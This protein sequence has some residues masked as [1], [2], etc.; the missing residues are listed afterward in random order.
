MTVAAHT[1]TSVPP[2]LT[3][4]L[5][6]SPDIRQRGGHV[7]KVRTSRLGLLNLGCLGTSETKHQRK[8]LDKKNCNHASDIRDGRA[9]QARNSA[10]MSGAAATV[11]LPTPG[12]PV[13][14]AQV[15]IALLV[16]VTLAVRGL[17]TLC[18]CM[19]AIGGG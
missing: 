12:G 16:C 9:P 17:T 10:P 6:T 13:L 15:D 1:R 14:F 7:R 11:M 5:P 3:S 4:V 19:S 8:T 2:L 18:R